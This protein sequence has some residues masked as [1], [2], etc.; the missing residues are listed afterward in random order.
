MLKLVKNKL[1]LVCGAAIGVVLSCSFLVNTAFARP[2][3]SANPVFAPRYAVTASG[4]QT[5]NL[6]LSIPQ[7]FAITR[8]AKELTT[9][10]QNY[11]IMGTSD[12]SKPVYFNGEEIKR[13]GTKGVFGVY[14]DLKL[15]T[16][17][18]T[19]KQGDKSQ[20]VTIIRKFPSTTIAKISEITQNS[21]FPSVH[22][23]AKV[24]EALKLSCTAPAG[25]TVSATFDGKSVQLKQVAAAEAG[26][27]ATFKGEITIADKHNAESVEKI[28]PV[29]YTMNYNG[30][31]KSYKS[32]GDIYVAGKNAYIAVRVTS[33]L[34]YIYPDTNNL[35]NFK[36]YIKTGGMDFLKVDSQSNAYFKIYSGGYIPTSQVEIVTGEYQVSNK[37]SGVSLNVEAK[38]ETFTFSGTAKPFYDAILGDDTFTLKLYNSHNTPD[39]SLTNSKLFSSVSVKNEN[40]STIYTFTF[41]NKSQYWGYNVSYDDNGGLSL[42][43]NYK[44]KLSGN[45]ATPFDGLVV[46]L[47]P[48]HGGTEPGALGFTQANGPMEKVVN[49]A[50]TYAIRDKLTAM[51]A[52]VYLTL[53]SDKLVTLDNRLEAVEEVNADLFISVHHNSIGE[54]VNS[55]TVYGTEVYYHNATSY[56]F[57]KNIMNSL[58]NSTGRKERFINRSYYRVTLLPQ[59][60]AILMELG[61]MCNPIEY[62]RM[63]NTTEIAK[64]ADAVANAIKTTLS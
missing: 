58:V 2:N 33:Y 57:A 21:M 11:Y 27:P 46:L 12:P 24:G 13:Q 1:N 44:P 48:G 59:C 62:E 14:V 52:T 35:A 15:G 51:G 37:L 20:T 63:T 42:R 8:P 36:E 9:T 3:N 50:H 6:D 26:V 7:T 49:L 25:A 4:S 54:N 32:S 47:D 64:T 22:G 17:S 19:F 40:K 30:T 60:P 43:L 34:G 10:Y 41:K 23:G 5:I 18:F 55:N 38:Q 39:V 16:N 29:T 28:G 53:D 56:N 45:A 31:T 61:Y